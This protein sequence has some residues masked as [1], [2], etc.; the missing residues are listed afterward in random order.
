MSKIISIDGP[1]GSGKT[2]IAKLL[3]SK[4]NSEYI[5]TGALYRSLSYLY[6]NEGKE[7]SYIFDNL[8]IKSIDNQNIQ[9]NEKMVLIK[10]LYTKEIT[11]YTSKLSQRVDIRDIVTNRVREYVKDKDLTVVE[12]RDI[13]SVVFKDALIKIYLDSPLELRAKRRV[14]Q[15]MNIEGHDSLA[16]RDEQD[17]NRLHSPLIIPDGAFI[18]DNENISVEDIV[19]QIIIEYK[20][21]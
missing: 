4:L 20:S 7:L 17:K 13:G 3:A 12:G 5:S 9:V 18:I 2:T 6:I 15:S 11:D 19:N 8:N 1:S 21:L 16:N 14:E 10:D